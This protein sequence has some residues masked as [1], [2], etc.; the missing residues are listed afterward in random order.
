MQSNYIVQTGGS[1]TKYDH[2]MYVSGDNQTISN[3]F[4]ALSWGYGMQLYDGDAGLT[5]SLIANNVTFDNRY[6]GVLLEGYGNRITGL[7]CVNNSVQGID[8][9]APQ[10]N[11]EIDH[12][13]IEGQDAI[14]DDWIDQWVPP[15]NPGFQIVSNTMN[16]P[17]LSG[18]SYLTVSSQSLQTNPIVNQNT[19]AG[20]PNWNL[21]YTGEMP[22]NTGSFS[23]YLNEVQADLGYNWDQLSQVVGSEGSFDADGLLTNMAGNPTWY[24]AA[25]VLRSYAEGVV[26]HVGGTPVTEGALT[27]P[28][29][30]EG[31]AFTQTVFHFCDVN[32]CD[33][34]GDYSA[35]VT[36][37]DG[38]TV[39][40]TSTA[41]PDGQIVDNSSGGFDVILSYTYSHAIPAN[42]GQTFSVAVTATVNHQ[43]VAATSASANSFSVRA[44]LYWEGG[45]SGNWTDARWS[46]EGSGSLEAWIPGSAAVFPSA[47]S[48]TTITLGDSNAATSLS[49]P[50]SASSLTFL[51]GNYS[52]QG[53]TLSLFLP[54]AAIDIVSGSV[55]IRSAVTGGAPDRD[56]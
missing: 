37:G 32:A 35:V 45:S 11:N 52:I 18:S 39:T 40:L 29:A 14:T 26:A 38:N 5:N 56:R 10:W 20:D 4:C 41:G 22:I 53:G 8:L 17:D 50:I 24:G 15:G 16:N 3:N 36:L 34:I 54:R 23:A 27:P 7:V 13:Y 55:T 19:Y 48:P 2:D 46:D 21:A 47:A 30:T 12:C 31:V 42:A 1:F 43:V 6:A 49:R 9:Y 28:D 25:S 44:C 51:R 33:T